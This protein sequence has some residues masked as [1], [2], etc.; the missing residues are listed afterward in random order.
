MSVNRHSFLFNKYSRDAYNKVTE[1]LTLT[2]D[3]TSSI[4][5]VQN[6]TVFRTHESVLRCLGAYTPF[7]KVKKHPAFCGA[8]RRRDRHG[9]IIRPL[10]EYRA[11]AL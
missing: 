6:G 1:T 11:A 4:E 7:R 5:G 2:Q 8:Y 3:V 10:L 9:R